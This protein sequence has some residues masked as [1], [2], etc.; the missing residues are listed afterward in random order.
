M[1]Q[2]RELPNAILNRNNTIKVFALAPGPPLPFLF[3][4]PR[5]HSFMYRYSHADFFPTNVDSMS[6]P[7]LDLLQ[8]ILVLINQTAFLPW[9][10]QTD[11]SDPFRV[12]TS[13]D[14]SVKCYDLD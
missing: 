2:F 5:K 3:G 1:S 4:P 14:N 10:L 8:H 9:T 12:S 13:S 7:W 6:T 11:A